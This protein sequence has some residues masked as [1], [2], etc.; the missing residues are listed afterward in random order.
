LV[1]V[2]ILE[3]AEQL[4]AWSFL[5]GSQI[6]FAGHLKGSFCGRNYQAVSG[7]WQVSVG[8]LTDLPSFL[9]IALHLQQVLVGV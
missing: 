1:S 3:D 7:S 8:I 9:G 4:M 6:S 2:F 5:T